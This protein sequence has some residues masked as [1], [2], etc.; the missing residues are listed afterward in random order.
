MA[1]QQYKL[2]EIRLGAFEV[3]ESKFLD[4]TDIVVEFYVGEVR[5]R[6]DG[7]EVL[8]PERREWMAP[9]LEFIMNLAGV[10]DDVR[11]AIA[12]L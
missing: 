3:T 12:S 8:K 10:F 1:R 9:G 7:W 5:R 4:G 2:R 6:R 11:D